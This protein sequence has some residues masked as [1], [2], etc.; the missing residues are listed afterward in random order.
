MRKHIYLNE[1]SNDII[2]KYQEK[3]NISSF[4]KA[5]NEIIEMYNLSSENTIKNMYEYMA[6]RI[7]EQLKEE[8]K[9]VKNNISKEVTDNINPSLKSLKYSSNSTNKDT[10]IIIEL[11]NGIYYKEDYGIV[12]TSVQFPTPGLERAI[13]TVETKIAKKHYKNSHTLD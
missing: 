3:N 2:L 8:L 13:D 9:N 5:L 12:P 11:L 6:D 4:S 7:A 10:Q 1:K